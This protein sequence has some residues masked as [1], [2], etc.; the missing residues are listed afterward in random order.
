M[1]LT[2]GQDSL[3]WPCKNENMLDIQKFGEENWN[4]SLFGS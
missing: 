2:F 4:E 1:I 3:I